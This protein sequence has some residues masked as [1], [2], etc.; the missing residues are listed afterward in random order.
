MSPLRLETV[1]A[2]VG[3]YFIFS[4]LRLVLYKWGYAAGLRDG[5]REAVVVSVLSAAE[6]E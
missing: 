1:A 4:A 2:F 6:G 5:R 3:G